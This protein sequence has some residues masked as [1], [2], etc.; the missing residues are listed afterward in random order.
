M[1]NSPVL[2]LA[3][4]TKCDTIIVVHLSN[5]AN[6]NKNRFSDV[7]I[8][9]IEPSENLGGLFSGTI[10]FD[11]RYTGRLIDLGYN[12]T[13]QQLKNLQSNRKKEGIQ[14]NLTINGD[15][16]YELVSTLSAEDKYRLFNECDFILNGNYAKIN[17]LSEDG[18]GKTIWRLI[19]GKTHMC[20]KK[21]LL[22][23]AELQGKMLMILNCLDSEILNIKQGMRYLF[24]MSLDI[25]DILLENHLELQ[26][27]T[28]VLASIIDHTKY[29][30]DFLAKK[31]PD[32]KSWGRNDVEKRLD[33]IRSSINSRI[34]ALNESKRAVWKK[35]QEQISSAKQCRIL[36][37]M[38][39]KSVVLTSGGTNTVNSVKLDS[40]W[41]SQYP[42][43]VEKGAKDNNCSVVVLH[44]FNKQN[45]SIK[46]IHATDYFMFLWFINTPIADRKSQYVFMIDRWDSQLYVYG[47]EVSADG[48]SYS[49]IKLNNNQIFSGRARFNISKDLDNMIGIIN[50]RSIIYRT[51]YLPA[52][53]NLEDRMNNVPNYHIQIVDP[54]WENKLFENNGEYF[55]DLIDRFVSR[56]YD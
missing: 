44:E 50:N 56:V 45:T 40:W 33:S 49:S 1:D 52:D 47:Y 31:Y 55:V 21:L 37:L 17:Y 14:E 34:Q 42:D 11:N 53:R 22:N 8:L 16:V 32:Y 20:R 25:S 35:Q 26:S 24:N 9:E 46:H 48:E 30:D 43:V 5:E 27:I 2:P 19:T 28:E 6:I 10:N 15:H 38:P 54:K 41:N 18:F 23:N 12:D 7:S 29:I 36:R 51:F 3:V 4:G 39:E 13:I